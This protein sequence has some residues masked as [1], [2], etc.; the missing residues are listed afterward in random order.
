MS[1]LANPRTNS[2]IRVRRFASV[3][4]EFF[5]ALETDGKGERLV[6]TGWTSIRTP[7]EDW[8]LAP[9]LA[10]ELTE[11]LK[12]A[13][14][15]QSVDFSDLS[16]PATTPFFQACRRVAQSIPCGSTISYIE[17]AKRAGSPGASRAAGQAMRRNP[18]PIVVPCHRVVAAS[19]QLGGF[20]GDWYRCADAR[21]PQ[22]ARGED[23]PLRP[24]DLKA[25]LLAR[26]AEASSHRR[27]KAASRR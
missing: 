1:R 18:T 13:L 9:R 15:G 17:L 25:A 7:P 27:P 5:L 14:A 20:S 10:P 3:G 26:E 22:G 21:S 24:T 12:A 8:Q 16:L 2:L 19:G 4:G 6:E 11:R 23:R